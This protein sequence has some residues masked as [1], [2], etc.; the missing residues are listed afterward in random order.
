MR[1]ARGSEGSSD[2]L[3]FGDSRI[4]LGILPRVLH[5]RIRVSAYNLGILGGQ[6]PSTYFLL[7]QVLERGNRP[8]AILVDFSETLLTFAPSANAACWAD[9]I[10]PWESLDLAWQSQ[11]PALAVSTVLHLLLPGWCDGREG[12]VLSGSLANV[13]RGGLGADESCVFERNWRLNHGAQV[14][15]REFVQVEEPDER[16]M[17]RIHPANE[18]YVDRFLRTAQGCGIA[19]YW[20]LPPSVITRRERLERTGGSVAYRQFVA[21]RVARYSCLTVLDGDRLPWTSRDFRDPLHLNRDGALRLSLAVAAVAG[22]QFPGCSSGPRWVD[23][24]A[25]DKSDLSKYQDT[26]EDLDQSR[27]ALKPILVG[28]NPGE[29][30]AW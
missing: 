4:K 5:D 3:C 12:S 29:A 15:P 22:P 13:G 18:V 11:D 25:N 17:W 1:A 30:N 23:L 20:I 28:Q 10:G 24:D 2:V 26:L 6:A 8:R 7:R 19:V 27:A 16:G 21:E 14:A 9:W